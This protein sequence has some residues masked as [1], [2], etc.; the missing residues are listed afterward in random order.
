MQSDWIPQECTKCDE[1]VPKDEEVWIDPESGEATMEGELFHPGCAPSTVTPKMLTITRKAIDR[2]GLPWEVREDDYD[3]DHPGIVV[4]APPI[5]FATIGEDGR[6]MVG[7]EQ[8]PPAPPHEIKDGQEESW[9][10]A[11]REAVS[12][13]FEVCWKAKVTTVIYSNENLRPEGY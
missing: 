9:W 13:L 5:Y 1:L 7:A 10:D 2:F 12:F 3:P 6:W 8:S 11:I 4:E